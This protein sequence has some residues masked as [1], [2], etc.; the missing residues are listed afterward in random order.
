MVLIQYQ[1]NYNYIYKLHGINTISNKLWTMYDILSLLYSTLCMVTASSL[2]NLK[3]QFTVDTSYLSGFTDVHCGFSETTF[4]HTLYNLIRH[5]VK[6]DNPPGIAH[7]SDLSTH[8]SM[9]QNSTDTELKYTNT[10]TFY[11]SP[12]HHKMARKNLYFKFSNGD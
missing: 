9:H 11:I 12:V 7:L 4:C 2:V 6:D 1:I 8:T 3:K 10:L 5:P